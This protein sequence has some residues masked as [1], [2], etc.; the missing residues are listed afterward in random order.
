[1]TV[2][3]STAT[4]RQ[5]G[6]IVDRFAN[7]QPNSTALIIGPQRSRISYADLAQLVDDQCD[8]LRRSGLRSGDVIA[9]SCANNIEFV[10][11]LLGAAR[12]GIV[13]AP[14]DPTLPAIQAR[15]RVNRVGACLTVTDARGLEPG[16]PEEDGPRWCLHVAPTSAT[17]VKPEMRLLVA[18]SA[19][20]AASPVS[21][22]TDRDALIM[23]TSGTTGMPKMVPWTHDN[24]AAS[25]EGISGAYQLGGGD[26][27][28]AAMPLF[29]G[30]GLIATLLTTLATGGALLLPARGK[31]S[32]H[33]FADDVATV[34]AT[35]YT[36][37]PTIHQILLDTASA[38]DGI[39]HTSRL[40]FIRSCSAPLPSAMVRRLETTFGVPVL[41]AYG[42]TEST[43]QASS[44]LP[45]ADERTRVHTVGAPTGLSVRIIDDGRT[46]ARRT[47]G[48]IW[49]HGPA[50]VRGYLQDAEATS[51]TFVD[52]WVRSGD[53]GSLDER[54]NLTIEGRIKDLI[55]RGGEKISP[56]HVE[57]VLTS[58]PT[59][60]EAA[61][62]GVPDDLYGERVA[63]LVVPCGGSHVDPADLASYSRERLS[64]FEIPE[65]IIVT[66]KLPMTAKGSV[67]RS[68]L[69][70]A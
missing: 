1:M 3:S 8:T 55:N 63:A 51:N 67:D 17:G 13:V 48:E 38:A 11:A 40:R 26:A 65:R 53:L 25:I 68:K 6:H 31:F 54:G 41:A 50:V 46:C 37:V 61:V 58:H 43:H 34:D 30:H 52:G 12:A 9:L 4:S 21:D 70:V 15:E 42:M 7:A 49:F 59:V 23:F 29:H 14:L 18:D 20:T 24:V 60:A 47:T 62:F 10:V 66:D 16:A 35:W 57:E 27:T 64:A 44:A 36:A 69:T 45:S 19:D 32:A 39:Q 2:A 28:V 56:E 33:T 5:L 22:L